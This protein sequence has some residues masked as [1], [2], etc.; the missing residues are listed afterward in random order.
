ML[1]SLACFQVT[2]SVLKRMF[3]GS[4]SVGITNELIHSGPLNCL[5][6]ADDNATVDP[7]GDMNDALLV[8]FEWYPRSSITGNV[9]VA[10]VA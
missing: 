7:F 9:T 4:S 6:T 5:A 2:V 8:G 3:D 10:G 1:A